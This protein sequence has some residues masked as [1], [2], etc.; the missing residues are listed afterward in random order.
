MAKLLYEGMLRNLIGEFVRLESP[1][2]VV[3]G[4]LIWYDQP[5]EYY[6]RGNHGNVVFWFN[7]VVDIKGSIIKVS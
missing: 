4:T 7:D 1:Q 2:K 5:G 6:V 3:E